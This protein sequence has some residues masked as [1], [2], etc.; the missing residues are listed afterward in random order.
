MSGGIAFGVGSD[1]SAIPVSG[2]A[3][4]DGLIAGFS[5]ETYNWPD[6][7]ARGLGTVDG[8]IQLKFDFGAGSLAGSISPSI[9]ADAKYYLPTMTFVD[10][11][12]SKGSTTFSGKFDTKLS[13]PN[14]FSGMFTGPQANE[15]IGNFAFPY[16]SQ[17][18]GKN[19]EAGGGFIAKH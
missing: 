11:V 5:T 3:T 16:T 9:Y 13:G 12:F 19:Y 14:A 2:S 4:F 8:T 10:T 1:P 18:D 7:S 6:W 15:L 17:I